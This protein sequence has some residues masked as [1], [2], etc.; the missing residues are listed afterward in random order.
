MMILIIF[1]PINTSHFAVFSE[2]RNLPQ[3]SCL[4]FQLITYRQPTK[5]QRYPTNK[6]NEEQESNFYPI[7]S[8]KNIIFFT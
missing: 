1:D 7:I 2:F 6:N 4:V 5:Y 8:G 3:F